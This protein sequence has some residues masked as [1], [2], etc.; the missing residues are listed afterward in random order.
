MITRYYRHDLHT[1]RFP[2]CR[3]MI[4]VCLAG[5]SVRIA[6]QNLAPATT[7]RADDALTARDVLLLHGVNPNPSAMRMFVEK[8]F[9]EDALLRGLP[10]MPP[11][12]TQVMLFA[13]QELGTGRSI[14]AVGLFMEICRKNFP[15]GVRQV[16]RLDVE[17]I[18]ATRIGQERERLER[19][20][21]FNAMVSLGWI[22]DPQAI[23]VIKE[24]LAREKESGFITQGALALG[25]LGDL[26]AL[27]AVMALM[28][29]GTP[30][31]QAG[32]ARAFY[33]LTGRFYSLGPTTSVA[34]KK[35][36]YKDLD[37]WYAK[38]GKSLEMSGAEIRR[39][40]LGAYPPNPEVPDLK[41]VRG[42]CMA[43]ADI[44]GDYNTSFAAREELHRRGQAVL[45]DLERIARDPL[46]DLDIRREALRAHV[47]IAERKSKDLLNDLRRDENESIAELARELLTRLE[48]LPKK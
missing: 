25:M 12:K 3:I 10:T 26:S 41:T 44:L 16:I 9:P 46:E 34:R 40:R 6:A 37:T 18:E 29:N 27:P 13:I 19:F 38:D 23:P 2:A 47:R 11:E 42:L 32:A 7:A 14:E 39:R 22:G 21:V 30:A 31:E 43:A 45:P 24:V 20:V 17:G 33:Y 4:L 28:K 48:Q 8:G 1:A 36:I 5:L 15:A 35:V